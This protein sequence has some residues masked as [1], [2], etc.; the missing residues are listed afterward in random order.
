MSLKGKKI[1]I[2]AG[3]TWVPIDSVRVI[4]N[5]ASGQTG[6]LL[7]REVAARA[8]KVTLILGPCGEYNLNS[9]IRIIRFRFFNELKDTLRRELKKV[10]YDIVIHSAAVSD[11]KTK[12]IKGKIVS[13]KYFDL[14]LK[15]LPKIIH[16]IRRM[17]PNAKLIMFKLES[18]ISD[19]VLIKRAIEARIKAGADFVVANRLNPYCAFIINKVDSKI[20]IRSKQELA[21]KLI[22]VLL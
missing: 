4:S 3:P 5:I 1:L 22:K 17:A 6:I 20:T 13:S 10:K 15:P 12:Q 8:G 11:F 16:D 2:T 19:R 7:A 14:R 18:D 9:S 21:K